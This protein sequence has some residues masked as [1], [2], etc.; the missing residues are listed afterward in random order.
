MKRILCFLVLCLAVGSSAV[1][2]EIPEH[3]QGR[4]NDY[5]GLL[6]APVRQELENQLEVFENETSN[7]VAVVIFPSLDGQVLEDVSMKIVEKWKLGTK[8]NDNGLL[9]LIAKEDRAVRIEVG[10]GLEGALPDAT[11]RLII[12]REIVPN[13]RQGRFDEG[14]RAAVRA[15]L[16]ATKGEYKP[17]AQSVKNPQDLEVFAVMA[18]MFYLIMPF[19]AYILILVLSH[20]FFGPTGLLG[21]IPFLLILE[22]IRRRFVAPWVKTYSKSSGSGRGGWSGGGWGGGGFS[23][24][25]FSGGGGSFGGGGA[26]GRW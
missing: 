6:S 11:C 4:V 23:G 2:L 24:G 8:K 5:A 1:A 15:M 22:L 26:S 3:P 14:I 21:A 25:G 13:F 7:Q 20:S 10:Y 19:F 17:S 18:L 16:E 12:D 9:L